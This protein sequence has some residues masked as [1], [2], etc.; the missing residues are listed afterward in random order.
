MLKNYNK[1]T[2][3]IKNNRREIMLKNYNKR[4]PNENNRRENVKGNCTPSLR[5]IIYVKIKGNCNKKKRKKRVNYVR[6]NIQ[7]KSLSTLNLP[8]LDAIKNLKS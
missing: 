2:P 4:R 5:I 7:K 3:K 6:K 1:K 8:L